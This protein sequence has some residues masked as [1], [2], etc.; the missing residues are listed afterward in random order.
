MAATQLAQMI[1]LATDTVM[2]GHFSKEALA[3]RR[4]GNTVFFFIWLLGSG[5]AIGGVAD[6]RPCPGPSTARSRAKPRDRRE[7][8]VVVRMGLWSVALM[9]LPL[10]AAAVLHPADPAGACSQEP[11]LAADAGIYHVGAGLGPALRAGV[12][13][14]AQFLHRAQPRRCR[15]WW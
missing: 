1:I 10:L 13:G 6:D 11:R 9:S 15:R 7:V 12:P 2:L 8:R 5:P 14:A 3:A 4:L